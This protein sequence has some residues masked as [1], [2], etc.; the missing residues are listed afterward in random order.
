MKVADVF[1]RQIKRRIEEVIKVELDE[2]EAVADELIEYVA[3]ERIQAAM[4]HVLD[5]YQETIENPAEDTNV[6]ISGFFG[7]GK[8]SFAKVLG[9]LVANPLVAG[10]PACDW[11][12]AHTTAPR[13]KQLLVTQIHSRART[14]AVF[15]DLLS[16]RNVLNEGESIVLPLYRALLARLGYS[17]VVQ[18][19]E[20]EIR[21]EE[22]DLYEKFAAR[23]HE[24]YDRPWTADHDDPLAKSEMSRVLHDIEPKTFETPDSFARTQFDITIDANWF[25]R[26]ALLLL[27]RRGQGASRVM[28]VVDEVGQ[29]VARDVHRVGDLQGLAEALQKT[30]GRLW[31]LATSQQ[32][33]ED[34]VESLEGNLSEL[35]RVKDRFPLK[36]DLLPSDIEDVVA[37]RVLDKS[38][39]GRAAVRAELTATRNQLNANA[40]LTGSRGA[41]LSE[42][43]TIRLY[44][45][46]PYQVRLFIDAV[47]ARR[48]GG[49]VGGANRTLLR[50][51]Q[52]LII[53]PGAGIGNDEVGRLA[54]VDRAYDV[55]ASIIPPRWRDEVDQVAVQHG[56]DALATRVLKVVALCVDVRDLTLDAHNIAVLLHPEM[57]AESLEADVKVAI[58]R[59]VAEGRIEQEASGCRLQSPEGKSWLEARNAITPRPADVNRLRKRLLQGPLASLSV[60]VGRTFTVELTV[61][62]EKLSKG[63]VP[64]VVV[65]RE[66]GDLGDLVTESRTRANCNRI[67][68]A[69]T[70]SN[71]TLQGLQELYKSEEMTN[72][73]QAAARGG[74]ELELV[75]RERRVAA[76]WEEKAR[77]GLEEDLAAGSIVFLGRVDSPPPGDLRTMGHKIVEE[78]IHEIYTRLG[79]FAAPLKATDP[80]L[81]LRD[82]TLDGVPKSLLDIGLIVVKP[83][84]REV[85]GSKGPLKAVLDAIAS[86]HGY[87][88]EVT[89]ASLETKFAAPPYGA[90]LEVVQAIVA[91]GVRGGL[92]DVR[93][94]G[95]LIKNPRDMRL[96]PVFKGPAAFRGA[97]FR[98]HDDAVPVG[99]RV[100][101]A[102]RLTSLVG[103]RVNPTTDELAATAREVFAA[104]GSAAERVRATLLGLG[105]AVPS[106]VATV[107][108]QVRFLSAGDNDGAVLTTLDVWSDLIDGRKAVGELA[109]LLDSQL[110]LLRAAKDVIATSDADLPPELRAQHAELRDLLDAGDLA[111]KVGRMSSI[112]SAISDYRAA[113]RAELGAALAARIEAARADIVARYPNVDPDVVAETL[114][115]LNRLVPAEGEEAPSELLK[116]RLESVEMAAAGVAHALDEVVAMER[117][118]TIS[119]AE[120]A[121]DLIRT[122][123]DL[124]LVAERLKRRVA[125]LLADDKEVRLT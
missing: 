64:L 121:P 52:Q 13:L 47:T 46:L 93:Y 86:Q 88:R 103:S 62:D 80:G 51:A 48:E 18:L 14:L 29:Y 45:M 1:R 97:I 102:K 89:G 24:L 27:E 77:R 40:K 87:G 118:A 26:R 110:D 104:D 60:N 95:D 22:K 81:V 9:Y 49:M 8:S 10:K 100:E 79:E 32:R 120:I 84:G 41:D 125:E 117:L 31:L 63:D 53:A 39:E 113:L 4:G 73:R 2:D 38:A 56:S 82:P 108:D 59:L 111:Q 16:S 19:A 101:L 54:T 11:F 76:E 36:V 107:A 116:A 30:R 28:F 50:L 91:A 3:T 109:T 6:W 68:W 112:V 72:R 92:L 21:L 58:E 124:E 42:E 20:E 7:S 85:E 106:A 78:R 115:R 90:S 122:N 70:L 119:V 114:G 74:E 94:Q 25:A 66:T 12:F 34:I 67:W 61:G 71:G 43:Q 99:Q 123:E 57:D 65:E 105:I 96:D 17:T 37:R 44:P 75:A 33:L 35:A 83:G 55:M 69:H 15:V 5:S 98:P 23:Y